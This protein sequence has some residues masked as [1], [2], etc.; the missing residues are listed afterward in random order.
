MS[1]CQSPC[2]S[3]FGTMLDSDL[4]EA[5]GYVHTFKQEIHSVIKQLETWD[6]WIVGCF[7]S[8]AFVNCLQRVTHPVSSSTLEPKHPATTFHLFE[9]AIFEFFSEFPVIVLI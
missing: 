7:S 4:V 9:G 8:E 3:T 6:R 5:H 2:F 1:L